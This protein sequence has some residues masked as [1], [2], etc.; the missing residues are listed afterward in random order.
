MF[1]NLLFN[2][3]PLVRRVARRPVRRPRPI[4]PIAQSGGS[5]NDVFYNSVTIVTTK[6][7][8]V[9]VTIV[10]T[11]TYTATVRDYF[12]CVDHAGLVTIT[13]PVCILGTVYIV[14]DCS[15]NAFDYPITIQGTGQTIDGGTAQINTNYGSVSFIF[16]GSEWSIV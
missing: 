15:G 6:P 16:N 10:T 12:L 4:Y 1:T 11:P 8:P 5:G 2:R 9:P 3:R 13:F 7:S 14:K